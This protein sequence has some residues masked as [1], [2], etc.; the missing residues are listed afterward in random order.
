MRSIDEAIVHQRKL[1]TEIRLANPDIQLFHDVG[2]RPKGTLQRVDDL[3]R[4][5]AGVA[6]LVDG[7]GVFSQDTAEENAVLEKYIVGVR[8]PHQP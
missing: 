4:Y 8:P 1:Y 2:I 6:D 5:Y 7:V 3:L